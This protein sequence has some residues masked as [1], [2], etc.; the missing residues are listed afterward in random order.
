MKISGLLLKGLLALSLA[1]AIPLC[2]PAQSARIH[3]HVTSYTGV[4]QN[5]GIVCLST[6]GLS[7]AFSFPVD[8]NGNYKGEA[9]AGKY[10]LIFRMSDT[11]AGE[12]ID[13]IHNVELTPG[14]DLEQ[15]DDMSRQEFID[16]LPDET[17]KQLEDL[18]KQHTSAPNQ[19]SLARTMDSDLQQVFQEFK[20][21][22]NARNIALRELGK[23]ASPAAV[24]AKSETIRAPRYTRIESLMQKDLKALRDSGLAGDET[25]LLENLGRAQIGLKKYGDAEHAF[26]RILELQAASAVPKPSVQANAHAHLGEIDIRAGKTAE[27]QT[28]FDTAVQFD[29]AHAALFFRTE[30]LLFLE[31]GKPEAQIAAAGKAI[32]NDPENPL[33]Y[34]IKANGMFKNAGIDP[35]S[36]HYDLPDGCAEA[37]Q[38]YLTLAPNGPYAAEA[39]SVLRRAEKATK[40]EN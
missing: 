25:P 7:P 26:K 5:A 11:P 22:D 38:K 35:A 8:A 17:K 10:A 34:Y 37:Y 15:N 28:S 32:A 13:I 14:A 33:G 24:D 4:A 16:E 29:P 21:A 39:Q 23:A 31:E 2:S 6:D 20:E 12:W 27:A 3:G 1:V 19:D 36:K 40:A 30:A 9:P 18:K